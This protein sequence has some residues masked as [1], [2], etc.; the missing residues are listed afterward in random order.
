MADGKTNE[1]QCITKVGARRGDFAFGSLSALVLG[2]PLSRKL[3][4]NFIITFLFVMVAGQTF[5]NIPTSSMHTV[6]CDF[7]ETSFTYIFHSDFYCL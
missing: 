4:G 5:S 3:F 6:V 7:Y 2:L 1:Q